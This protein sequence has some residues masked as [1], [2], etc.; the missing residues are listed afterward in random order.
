VSR[1]EDNLKS[2]DPMLTEAELAHL[3]SPTKPTF[4]FPAA[5]FS[6][7]SQQRNDGERCSRAAVGVRPREDRQTALTTN[8]AEGILRPALTRYDPRGTGNLGFP[9]KDTF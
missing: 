6:R 2:L 8:G 7:D 4:G 5:D 1:L 9:G 3:D